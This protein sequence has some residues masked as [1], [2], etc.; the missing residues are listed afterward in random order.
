VEKLK[1]FPLKSGPTQGCPLSPLF[2]M[3]LEVF[4]AAI[5]QER[6]KRDTNKKERSLII[7][8]ANI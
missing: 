7:P 5:T 8:I 2:N 4:A 3:V 1:A 6:N